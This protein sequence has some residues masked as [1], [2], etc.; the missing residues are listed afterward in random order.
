MEARIEDSE[1]LVDATLP[2]LNREDACTIKNNFPQA[3]C[4]H[5]MIPDG[6]RILTDEGDFLFGLQVD[7]R[8]CLLRGTIYDSEGEIVPE[9]QEDDFL[10]H[11]GPAV[12]GKSGGARGIVIR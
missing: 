9:E 8:E 4:Q 11:R 5:E 6:Y 7:G 3:G 1:F 12:L 2:L 10:I